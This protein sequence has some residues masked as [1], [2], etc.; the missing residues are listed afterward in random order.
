MGI[1]LNPGNEVFRRITSAE[2]YVDKSMLLEVTNNMLDTVNSYVCVSR[3]RRFGKTVA[4]NMIAAYYSKGCDSSAIFDGLKISGVPG[5]REHLNK[6]NVIKIDVNSEYQNTVD[7]E[8]LIKSLTENIKAEMRTEFPDVT[9]EES[10]SFANCIQKTYAAN[11]ATFIILMDEYDVLVREQVSRKLFD[12]FLGFLNGLF[13]SDTIRP[14]ISLAYLTGILPIVRDKVQSKLN[15]F[16][17]YT[18]LDAGKFAEFVGFTGDEVKALCDRYDVDFDECRLWYDGYRQYDHEIYNPESVVRS[19]ESGNFGS[20]WGITSSY[21]VISDRLAEN[22]AGVKEDV[23]RMLSGEKVD[24]DPGLYLNTVSGFR[25]RDDVFTYLV[26]LGYLAYDKNE[27]TCRIPNKE[28]R[29]EWQRALAV[30]PDY[31]VTNEIIRAS[32][33]LL[34]E[35][36]E[37]NSEAVSKA[38]DESHIHVSSNRSYNNEDVLQSAIYLAYIY[39]LNQYMAVREMTAGKGF[40]DV[41]YI[42]YVKG[43][44]AL[45]IE[46]KH[47]KTSVSALEQ[48]KDRKYFDSLSRYSG[49]ILLIGINYD[50]KEKTHSCK[51]EK[52]VK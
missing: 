45:V 42:P 22:F 29:L 48:I 6:H 52:I 36:L 20:Y 47:N 51:I 21:E 28:V 5:Y 18:M 49:D 27:G 44:P 7:K 15:N 35:T 16:R 40:A 34:K 14:A 8:H 11:G 23:I 24:V 13:K 46:L 9:F 38:L 17:E 1:Y 31:S 10:D 32:K 25:L 41:V 4:G 12:E 19:I 30:L 2:I 33:V 3:P 37:G 43:M 50:E 39:A 26:H